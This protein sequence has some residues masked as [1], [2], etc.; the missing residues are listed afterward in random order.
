MEFVFYFIQLPAFEV[1]GVSESILIKMAR[2]IIILQDFDFV[3]TMHS[4]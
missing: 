2:L 1:Y 3:G 4:K